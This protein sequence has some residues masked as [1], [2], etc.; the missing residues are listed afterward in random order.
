MSSTVK[1]MIA[2]SRRVYTDPSRH[3]GSK[4]GTVRVRSCRISIRLGR[5]LGVHHCIVVECPSMDIK[6]V[7]YEWGLGGKQYYAC[8]KIK[9]QNCTV[10]TSLGEHTL[11]EVHAAAKAASRGNHYSPEYNCN[12]WTEAVAKTLG[13]NIEVRWNCRCVL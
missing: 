5:R 7:V 6:W 10:A 3:T 12:H 2:K 11:D 1:P 8:K 13:H 9:G 4:I